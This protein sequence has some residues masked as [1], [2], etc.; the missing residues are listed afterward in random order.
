MKCREDEYINIVNII[1][2]IHQVN[3]GIWNAAIS[4]CG[5]L[6][7]K[8][9]VSWIVYPETETPPSL[10]CNAIPI[11]SV[12]KKKIHNVFKQYGFNQQN[13]IVVT[14]GCWRFPTRV[15]HYLKKQGFRW[16]Y[17]PHGMLEPWSM[18]HKFLKKFI[19]FKLYEK[20]I[21]KKADV[22]RAV[23]SPEMRNLEMHYG[24]VLLIPNGIDLM[25]HPY[26]KHLNP[27][28]FLFLG[29]LHHKKG[30][31]ELVKGWKASS[32]NNNPDFELIVAGPDDGAL[33]DLNAVIKNS[34]NIKYIGA[35]FGKDK[36][37]LLNETHFFALPSHSEGFPTSVVEAMGFGL[38]PLISD[39]CNFPEA[40][41][42]NLAIKLNPNI[43][44]IALQLNLCA[45]MTLDEISE[46]GIRNKQ[47]I[48]N[49]Y[50]NQHI[51]MLQQKTY[52]ELFDDN[53]GRPNETT[54]NHLKQFETT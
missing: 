36:L 21:S 15:G 27:I 46:L 22:I 29:R 25:E 30:V 3:Y 7:V 12:N 24:N 47:F 43:K 35:V 11:R 26:L 17:V 33:D 23:G 9:F 13:T 54:S 48:L 16:M 14:H 34:V 5:E 42:N 4:T 40:F 38:V 44:Q 28:R 53:E 41:E 37:N 52:Q 18:K 51:A 1:D 19:Y 49:N 8:G 32:L 10:A 50:T 31:V 20:R 2:N 45:R 39:G 6:D